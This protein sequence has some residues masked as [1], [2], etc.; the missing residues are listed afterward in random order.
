MVADL[1]QRI[2]QSFESPDK[3]Y[4]SVP[5]SEQRELQPTAPDGRARNGI[6][7][8]FS[9]LAPEARLGEDALIFDH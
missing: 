6:P 7:V 1:L 2:R 5:N 9:T 8:S 4:H 3:N